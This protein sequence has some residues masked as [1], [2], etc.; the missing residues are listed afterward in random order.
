MAGVQ[1]PPRKPLQPSEEDCCGQGC[2][3][4]VHDIYEEE[5]ARYR[6][7]LERYEAGLIGDESATEA[8]NK[9]DYVKLILTQVDAVTRDTNLY[10]FKTKSSHGLPRFH[11]GQHLLLRQ[12]LPEGFLTRQYTIISEPQSSR[13]DIQVMIKLYDKGPMS[14]L[15]KDWQVGQ[16]VPWKGPLGEFEYRQNEENASVVMFGVGTG[17]APLVQIARAIVNN[18]EDETFVKLHFGFRNVISILLKDELKRLATFWNVNLTIHF[19]ESTENLPSLPNVNFSGKIDQAVVSSE[20]EVPNAFYLDCGTR[21]FE[22]SVA[23]YLDNA[24]VVKDKTHKF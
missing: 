1:P 10:T 11:H 19:S 18:P 13:S 2:P 4:C 9:D 14:Q 7:A 16:E 15:I 5:L 8:L 24:K 3:K 21:E 12:D 6:Q 23:S 17:I 20:A 22:K